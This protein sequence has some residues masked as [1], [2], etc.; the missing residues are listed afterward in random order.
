[1]RRHARGDE[2]A[3]LVIVL[4]FLVLFA[5]FGAALIGL[6][7]TSLR[8]SNRLAAQRSA[9]STAE[10]AVDVAIRRGLTSFQSS[11]TSIANGQAWSCPGASLS[12]NG[13]TASAACTVLG[14]AVSGDANPKPTAAITTIGGSIV[15]SK[16]GTMTVG[17]DVI[18]GGSVIVKDKN[19]LMQVIG[20]ARSSS[21][22]CPRVVASL[23]V[24]CPSSPAPTDPAYAPA[25]ATAPTTVASVPSTCSSAI[26]SFNPPAGGLLYNDAAALT[27]LTNGKTPSCVGK[28]IWFRPGVHYF[29]FTVGGARE[30]VINDA[31]VAVVGGAAKGGWDVTPS[32]RPSF[33]GGCDA[34]A[35]TGSPGAQLIF[36]GPSRLT[37]KKGTV[38]IC[39]AQTTDQSIAIYGARTDTGGYLHQSGTILKVAS[40]AR[41][42]VQGTLY[43]PLGVVDL[44]TSKLVTSAVSR[45]IVV[46]SL[47][48]RSGRFAGKGVAVPPAPANAD[49]DVTVRIVATVDGEDRIDAVVTYRRLYDGTSSYSTSVSRW[50]VLR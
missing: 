13:A 44:D 11:I 22:S 25:L 14:T 50:E 10:G 23:G 18:S 7:G 1:M 45:G 34:N 4:L 8:E 24:T 37:V 19:G 42:A 21:G 6:A 33:P 35:T 48:L 46:K 40:R 32:L 3:I 49:V 38:E 29:N 31:A 5:S 16:R 39:R 17:G 41:V 47:K 9:A 27:K 30:W 20:T 36:G 2:G 43:A 28:I 15:Q 12:A 26:V